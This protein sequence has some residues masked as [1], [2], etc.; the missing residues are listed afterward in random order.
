MKKIFCT[1]FIVLCLAY[2]SFATCG[3]PAATLY[4]QV[5]NVDTG[6]GV[7]GATLVMSVSGGTVCETT[8]TNPFGYYQ[9][10]LEGH[11]TYLISI[12][13]KQYFNGGGVVNLLGD[14]Q[15]DWTLQHQ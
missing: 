5:T 15:Q 14:T 4:G 1:L 12:S 2:A 11:N 13:A 3:F 8:L 7:S 9:F 10:G 6:L